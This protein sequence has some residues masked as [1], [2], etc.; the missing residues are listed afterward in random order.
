MKKKNG[1]AENPDRLNIIV[2]GTK[3]M[4][5]IVAVSN[6]RID[7]EIIG[8]ISASAKVVIGQS[9]TVK[10]NLVCADAD[11]EGKL[12]GEI[13]VEKLLS[14][15]STAVIQGEITTANIQVEEGA[16]FSGNCK[17]SNFSSSG[18]VKSVNKMASV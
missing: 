10:G 13:K 2:E 9:G 11:I 7:G 8:N 17:M 4:G 3:I 14:L 6:V 18:S 15:R 12:D 5:D 1:V 16:Q